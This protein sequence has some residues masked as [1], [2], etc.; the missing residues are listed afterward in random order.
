MRDGRAHY[1]LRNHFEEIMQY[2][3]Y[4]L[5]ILAI[6]AY[7]LIIQPLSEA[8]TFNKFKSPET[9]EAT[10][11]EALTCKLRIEPR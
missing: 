8:A 9:P 2:I 11:F 3:L 5:A 4:I 6:A 1:N 10:Y 7:G